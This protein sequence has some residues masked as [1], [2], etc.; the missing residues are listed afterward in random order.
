MSKP[1]HRLRSEFQRS[2]DLTCIPIY[3]FLSDLGSLPDAHLHCRLLTLLKGPFR[4]LT[5]FDQATDGS[6]KVVVQVIPNF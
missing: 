4:G 1:Q 2:Q 3:I 6:T 5:I